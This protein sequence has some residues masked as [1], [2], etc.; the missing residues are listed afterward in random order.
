MPTLLMMFK[1]PE[2]PTFVPFLLMIGLN[3]GISEGCLLVSLISLVPKEGKYWRKTKK[4]PPRRVHWRAFRS[5]ATV[6]VLR[7]D[8]CIGRRYGYCH[9]F[10]CYS[11]LDQIQ[12]DFRSG[13]FSRY[14]RRNYCPQCTSIHSLLLKGFADHSKKSRKPRLC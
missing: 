7:L 6:C 4:K 9:F 10:G 12:F 13:R 5:I 2:N 11:H 14:R 8:N 3:L 1:D